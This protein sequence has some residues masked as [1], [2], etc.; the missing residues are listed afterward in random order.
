MQ[1][2]AL[3]IVDNLVEFLT[4][5]SIHST[6]VYLKVRHPREEER[7]FLRIRLARVA[8]NV[9]YRSLLHVR[10]FARRLGKSFF[11]GQDDPI[12]GKPRLGLCTLL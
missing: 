8:G 10:R 2:N 6:C 9:L 4:N 5:V 12:L 11:S 1:V 3:A 7:T